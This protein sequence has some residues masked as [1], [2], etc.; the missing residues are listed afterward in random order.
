MSAR[1]SARNMAIAVRAISSDRVFWM[2]WPPDSNSSARARG[3]RRLDGRLHGRI[4][5][6]RYIEISGPAPSSGLAREA[7][8]TT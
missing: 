1:R 5:H 6:G 3:I 4:A 8:Q 7:S 2:W